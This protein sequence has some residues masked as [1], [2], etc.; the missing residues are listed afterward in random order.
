MNGSLTINTTIS[1]DTDVDV[2]ITRE[3]V[4]EA[5]AE[6]D[7]PSEFLPPDIKCEIE[8][9]FNHFAG[10]PA[11]EVPDCVRELVW[12]TIGRIL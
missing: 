12:S 1:V 7:D 6:C 10:T 11:H 2:E 4:L 5:I 8:A 9:V 3:Q